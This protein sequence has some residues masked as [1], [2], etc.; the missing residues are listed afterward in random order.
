MTRLYNKDQS[1][2]LSKPFIFIEGGMTAGSPIDLYIV[3]KDKTVDGWIL[4]GS[5]IEKIRKF[6]SHFW[7]K[8]NVHWSIKS[9]LPTGRSYATYSESDR[10]LAKQVCKGVSTSSIPLLNVHVEGARSNQN[11]KARSIQH[12]YHYRCRGWARSELIAS[13]YCYVH[14]IQT[15][16]GGSAIR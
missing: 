3:P 10:I 7:R 4:Q 11:A 15:L 5:N 13:V 16:S 1:S 2:E 6:I 12:F 14:I 9:T 8:W